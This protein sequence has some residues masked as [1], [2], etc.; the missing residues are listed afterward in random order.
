[1]IVTVF[2]VGMVEV[3]AYQIINMIPMR[4]LFMAA[5]RA[6]SMCDIVPLALMVGGA[7]R[8]V[9]APDRDGMLVHMAVMDMMQVPIMEVVGM[10]VMAY[11][12]VAAIRTVHMAMRSVFS[13]LSFL[14]TSS[15]RCF[16]SNDFAERTGQM[17]SAV[18]LHVVGFT[19]SS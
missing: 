6:V 11:R 19:A 12:C 4:H 14:H 17:L 18:F 8:R 10:P 5:V 1:M 13:T 7:V 9:R 2:T 16:R 15:F 3:S